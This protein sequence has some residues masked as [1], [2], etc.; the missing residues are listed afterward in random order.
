M[1]VDPEASATVG[2][3]AGTQ[4]GTDSE[5]ERLRRENEGLRTHNATV[6]ARLDDLESKLERQNPKPATSASSME[7]KKELKI[8]KAEMTIKLFDSRG[9][10][11]KDMIKMHKIMAE[12][13]KRGLHNAQ[14]DFTSMED[15][16]TFTMGSTI[17]KEEVLNRCR[18]WHWDPELI[19]V[20]LLDWI[21]DADL[22][23]VEG[24]ADIIEPMHE[25]LHQMTTYS[26]LSDKAVWV[27]NLMKTV[28]EL[29]LK[30]HQFLNSYKTKLTDEE[31]ALLVDV[32]WAITLMAMKE[33]TVTYSRDVW[34]SETK[35]ITQVEPENLSTRF[36][37][38]VRR[39]LASP[40]VSDD[41][42]AIT[43]TPEA[44]H[45]G[46]PIGEIPE[47]QHLH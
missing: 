10:T 1:E 35:D 40:G 38:C 22:K 2:G 6:S 39:A 4:S 33:C 12:A 5:L 21:K 46:G 20:S 30:R 36:D 45:P 16:Y 29:V 31:T 19:E 42:K 11:T 13:V 14:T 15:Y 26:P 25:F 8:K 17:H 3:A 37:R 34:N 44:R 43:I 41:D 27:M 7:P 23:L 47:A 9:H 28:T 24:Q 32:R 18:L